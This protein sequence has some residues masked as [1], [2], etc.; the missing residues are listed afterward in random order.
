MSRE[1][2]RGMCVGECPHQHAGLKV[3]TS[4]GYD[5]CQCVTLVNTHTDSFDWEGKGRYNSFCQQMN[6]GCAG[7]TVRTLENACHT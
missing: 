1:Y 4:S 6:A 7:K 3:P 5:L 2:Q